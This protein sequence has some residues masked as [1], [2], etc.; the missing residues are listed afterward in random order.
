MRAIGIILTL[1]FVTSTS[2]FA[3]LTYV[4]ASNID[5]T[6]IG[7]VGS[8]TGPLADSG[9]PGTCSYLNDVIAPLYNETFSNLNATIYIQMGGSGLGSG[10]LPD[11]AVPYSTYLSDLTSNANKTGNA[12]QLSAVSSLK[13]YDSSAY[14]SGYVTITGAIASALGYSKNQIDGYTTSDATCTLNQSGCYNDIL[15]IT[16]PYSETGETQGLY[17]RQDGG[18][19]QSDQYDFYSVVEHETDEAL[20]TTSCI[21]TQS[22][23]NQGNPILTN[24]CGGNPSA[25]DLFRYSAPGSLILDSSVVGADPSSSSTAYFSYNGGTTN[26]ANGAMYN[27]LANGQDYGDYS[28]SCQFVQDAVGCLGQS[29]DVTTDGGEIPILVAEGFDLATPE[30]GTIA[31]LGL[32]LCVLAARRRA[33]GTPRG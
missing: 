24:W 15:T 14:D 3:G 18:S 20:G 11:N 13:T 27:T 21:N 5:T 30:P 12:E 2:A 28:N 8:G 29:F 32:G 31:L 10:L 9:D 33:S 25:A 4:C 7:P 26:G 22:T 1:G 23:D 19:I 16:N 17:W 6:D